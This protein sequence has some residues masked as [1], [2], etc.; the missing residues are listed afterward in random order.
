MS[1]RYFSHEMWLLEL[2]DHL[3]EER[4]AARTSRQCLAVA[5]GFLDGLDSS[6]LTSARH[7]QEASRGIYNRHDGCIVAAMAIHPIIKVGGVS[8]PMAFTCFCAWFKASGH[9]YQ[10]R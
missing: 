6:M 9:Q 2:K 4:Y 1:N 10:E 7:N 8:T 3:V 5:R